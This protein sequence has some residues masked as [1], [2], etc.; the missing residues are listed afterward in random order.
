MRS[1]LFLGMV[2]TVFLFGGLAGVSGCAT[3]EGFGEDVQRGGEAIE[4]AAERRRPD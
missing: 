2:L 3:V 1:N 4:G